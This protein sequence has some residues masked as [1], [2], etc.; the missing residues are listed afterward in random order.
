MSRTNVAEERLS[1]LLPPTEE[2]LGFLL[3]PLNEYEI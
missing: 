2:L 1:I 3:M